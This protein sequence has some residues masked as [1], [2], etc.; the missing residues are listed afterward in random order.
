VRPEG[1]DKLKKFIHLTGSRNRD[2]PDYTRWRRETGTFEAN[3][4]SPVD[5]Q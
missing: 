4:G 5:V 3:V 1:L 2:L